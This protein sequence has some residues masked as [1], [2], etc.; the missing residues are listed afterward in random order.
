MRYSAHFLVTQVVGEEETRIDKIARTS[1]DNLFC[2]SVQWL[3]S[4][5]IL[6]SLKSL[7]SEDVMDFCD[8]SV[9]SFFLIS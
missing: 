3:A 2:C 1:W 8:F 4:L 5:P 6:L 9:C 7:Q